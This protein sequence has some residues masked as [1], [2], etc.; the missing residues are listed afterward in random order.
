MDPIPPV[1]FYGCGTFS[2]LQEGVDAV[3]EL[4]FPSTENVQLVAIPPGPDPETNCDDFLN[5]NVQDIPGTV[6]VKETDT[7]DSDIQEV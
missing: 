7:G 2:T 3:I 4:D 5:D 6:E 1:S